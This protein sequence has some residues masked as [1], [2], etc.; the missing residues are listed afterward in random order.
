LEPR[1]GLPTLYEIFLSNVV[2][3]GLT[4]IITPL[5]LDAAS[6]GVALRR[7]GVQADVIHIDAAHDFDAC[8]GDLK[9]YWPLIADT[10]V[11]ICDDYVLWPGVTR[12][13]NTFAAEVE[14]P[15]FG[16]MMK[17]VLPKSRT[18]G[19]EM[20]FGETLQYKLARYA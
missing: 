1:H 6:A 19:F 14:R 17:A 2:H 10:G 18:L 5:A 8:Y 9:N 20:S 13:V 4:D 11:M 15:I 3:S 7:L 12:A 16:S